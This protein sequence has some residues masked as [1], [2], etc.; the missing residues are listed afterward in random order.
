MVPLPASSLLKF[1][2]LCLLHKHEIGLLN[3][4]PLPTKLDL[5][6]S[7]RGV[8]EKRCRRRGFPS[9]SGVPGFSRCSSSSSI[10]LHPPGQFRFLMLLVRCP[11]LCSRGRFPAS[12]TTMV[13]QGLLPIQQAMAVRCTGGI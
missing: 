4:F 10:L 9:C 12:S 2:L 13:Q 7:S 11:A 8:L 1:T 3:I 5:K 6:I